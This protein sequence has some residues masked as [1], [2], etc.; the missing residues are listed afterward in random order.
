VAEATETGTGGPLEGLKVLDLTRF[1]PGGF[2]TLLLADLGADVVKVEAPGMGDGV[3]TIVRNG[4]AASHFALNRG[5]RSVALD[6][7][8]EGAAEVLDRLVGWADVVIEAHKPGQLDKLGIGYEAMSAR[9]PALVWCSLTGFGDFG[10]NAAF[11]GHDVTYLGVSG[12]L[13]RLADGAPTLPLATVSLPLGATMAVVGIL[14]A[15]HQATRTGKGTRLDANMTD[16]AM[17]SLSEE[18]AQAAQAP[19]PPWPANAARDCYR[20]ADGRYVTVA[21]GEPR[22]WAAL[23]EGLEVPELAEHRFGRGDDA[24]ARARLAE[25]FATRPAA[26]WVAEP[27]LLGGVGAINEVEELLDDPQVVGRDSL[28][29]IPGSEARVLANPI[30]FHGQGGS[31][32]SHGLR[33]PPD[34]GADTDAV[35]RDLGLDLEAVEGLRGAGVIS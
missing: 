13:A 20:C 14:A 27:G 18:V 2:G 10:P 6:L 1:L 30:R 3:R 4:V 35:L 23:C 34:L 31:A 5:K 24:A 16:A 32:A 15:V 21:A 28:V 17:W 29:A 26:D 12:L 33:P 8:K 25:V 22:T 11:A 7:R 19:A 9:Y